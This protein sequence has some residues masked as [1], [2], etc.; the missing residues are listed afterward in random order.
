MSTSQ[1]RPQS[2][3]PQS[4]S[5]HSDIP[6]SPTS[7]TTGGPNDTT[8]NSTR[9]PIIIGGV[10]V[11]GPNAKGYYRLKW[12][13]PDGTVGDTSGSRDEA[14]ARLKAHDINSRLTQAAGP[15][16]TTPLTH[17]VAAFLAEGKSPY[18]EKRPYKQA[19]L[20]GLQHKLRRG[21]R[22]LEHVRAMDLDRRLCDAIR[23]QAGTHNGVVEN[24]NA[25]RALLH[26]GYQDGYFTAAQVELLPRSSATPQPVHKTTRTLMTS[27]RHAQRA[28]KVG[29]AETYIEDEDC[30]NEAQIEALANALGEHFPL[31]GVLACELAANTG[32]RWGEQFQLTAADV[33]LDGCRRY[34][35]PHIHINWQI[36]STRKAGKDGTGDRRDLP[37]GRKTRVVPVPR[38]SITDYKLRKAL[39]AR[40]AAAQ[41]EQLTGTNRE[42]LLFPAARGGLIWHSSFNSDHLLPAMI[43][44]GLPVETYQVTSH[45]WDARRMVYVET[46]QTERHAIFSWHSLRHRFARICVDI[47][48]LQD[49]ELMALGG[50][51]NIA[52]VRNRYY[53]SGDDN[54]NSGL[55][56]FD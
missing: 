7:S 33:H 21:L 34:P 44:A 48:G 20:D 15:K 31:W 5:A 41:A 23:S 2:P 54:A 45:P 4:L 9:G 28:R 16:A 10:T 19:Q 35:S 1:P 53:E 3:A 30:P 38:R 36:A 39:R 40:V 26:W 24:T 55:A 8:Q 6:T 25:L 17:V 27:D 43:A 46:V 47:R 13:E 18:K 29:Q 14:Y 50:W 52:T 12:H 51:E 49:G 42:A 32:I 56:K 11:T 37:K 22:G